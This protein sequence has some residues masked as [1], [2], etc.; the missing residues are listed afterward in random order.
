MRQIRRVGIGS[1]FKVGAMVSALLIAILGGLVLILYLI[2]TV[3]LGAVFA[4]ATEE[5]GAGLGFATLS[6]VGLIVGYIVQILVGG[7]VG[8]ITYALAALVYN[9]IAG[10]VGG[11]E[12]ELEPPRVAAT[13]Q[14]YMPQPQYAPPPPP[15]QYR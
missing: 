12:I 14:P 1:A 6:A 4:G 7:V 10:W 15:Q 5:L 9:I 11:I 3:A 13:P 2:V 8:G